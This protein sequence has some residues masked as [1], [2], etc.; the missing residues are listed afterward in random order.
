MKE[1]RKTE[2]LWIKVD[3]LLQSGGLAQVYSSGIISDS[4][5]QTD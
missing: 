2:R 3:M 5:I 1:H 4:N